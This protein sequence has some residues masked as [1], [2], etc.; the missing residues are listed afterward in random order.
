MTLTMACT[1]LWHI[2][3]LSSQNSAAVDTSG[4]EKQKATKGDIEVDHQERSEEQGTDSQD[5]SQRSSSRS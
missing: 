5:S 4:D 2:A 3:K 1:C